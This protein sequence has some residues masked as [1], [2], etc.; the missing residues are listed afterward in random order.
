MSLQW[1]LFWNLVTQERKGVHA[2]LQE[3]AKDAPNKGCIFSFEE[4]R[5]LVTTTWTPDCKVDFC[6]W[7]LKR[8]MCV[9][10]LLGALRSEQFDR[11]RRG[12]LDAIE[13]LRDNRDH[14]CVFCNGFII[15]SSLRFC[16]SVG[17]K[18]FILTVVMDSSDQW[19]PPSTSESSNATPPPQAGPT[20]NSD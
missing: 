7:M 4:F 8:F 17:L 6:K 19:Q 3:S 13:W 20:N 2:R 15:M 11:F 18:D 14:H 16:S 1:R 10:H 9:T 5:K 12:G